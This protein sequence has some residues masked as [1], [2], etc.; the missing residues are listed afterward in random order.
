ML[1]ACTDSVPQFGMAG[2]GMGLRVGMAAF[3]RVSGFCRR[4]LDASG[5]LLARCTRSLAQMEI[6]RGI[7]G[8]ASPVGNRRMKG[9]EISPR[10]TGK[11]VQQIEVCGFPLRTV[12]L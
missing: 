7:F 2:G 4:E 1:A 8:V 3:P 9:A 10:S 5:F 12:P 6:W 11:V